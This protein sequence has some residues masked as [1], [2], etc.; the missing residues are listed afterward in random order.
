MQQFCPPQ[1]THVCY[2]A[3]VL[4]QRDATIFDIG[5]E[6]RVS[7]GFENSFLGPRP[8]VSVG[9]RVP[10]DRFRGN[11]QTQQRIGAS[12]ETTTFTDEARIRCCVAWETTRRNLLSFVSSRLVVVPLGN[13]VSRVRRSFY[14]PRRRYAAE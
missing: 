2:N 13:N 4:R 6:A 7:V 14:V 3:P 11:G 9:S 10:R 5:P 1:V 12:G 8:E